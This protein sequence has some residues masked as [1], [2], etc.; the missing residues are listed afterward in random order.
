[1]GQGTFG[2]H[3]ILSHGGQDVFLAKCNS[4]GIWDWATSIGSTE[5]DQGYGVTV[6]KYN[7]IY[8]TGYFTHSAAFGSI[9]LVSTS[10]S[11]IF[12]ARYNESGTCIWAKKADGG[13][14]NHYGFDITSDQK[15]NTFVTGGMIDITYFDNYT[16][17]P[18]GEKT[19]VAKY[20]SSGIC[21]WAIESTGDSGDRGY[22]I[23]ADTLDNVFL[24]GQFFW[25]GDYSFGP[26]S[27]N[28]PFSPSCFN[29]SQS[30]ANTFIIKINSSI[31]GIRELGEQNHTSIFPNPVT[32]ILNISDAQTHFQN[33]TIDIKNTLGQNILSCP[34]N[35]EIDV[36][37]LPT[38]VYFLQIKTEDKRL[39]NTKFI[40]E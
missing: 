38:G 15:G 2:N 33:S 7:H 26:Y 4:N 28:I 32:S 40:K 29:S 17:I 35:P 20:D 25:S 6:D 12:T 3:N 18:N 27:F 39:L 31:V 8:L 14:G 13:A 10:A 9:N 16:V 24:T 21:Q 34:F 22:D 23:K 37:A 36:S 1:M 19:F 11:A 5:Y 30:C